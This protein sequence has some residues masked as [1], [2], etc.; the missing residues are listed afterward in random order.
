MR[1]TIG[2]TFALLAV[3][4]VPGYAQTPVKNPS[5]V[6][7]LCPDHATDDQHE[8]DIVREADGVVVA[9]LLG[10]DPPLVGSEVVIPVNVQPVAFGQYRF[11]V[12]AVAGLI[13]SNNSLSSEVWERAPGRPTNVRP[14]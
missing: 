5:G 12:R 13:K 10:G 1:R 11:V 6:A 8:V 2:L 3:Q 4:V 14:Q 7:F 9:T